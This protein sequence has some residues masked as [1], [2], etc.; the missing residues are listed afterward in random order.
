M[1]LSEVGLGGLTTNDTGSLLE[2]YMVRH[3]M[4]IESEG[5]RVLLTLKSRWAVVAK[6][7]HIALAA[8][9]CRILHL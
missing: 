2:D 5:C 1:L 7:P 4:W 9:N 6:I 3:S 8:A